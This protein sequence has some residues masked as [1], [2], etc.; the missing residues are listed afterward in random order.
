MTWRAPGLAEAVGG[1]VWFLFI[2]L[3]AIQGRNIAWLTY[4]YVMPVAYLTAVTEVIGIST[5]AYVGVQLFPLSWDSFWRV[6]PMI[7]A[8]GTGG[9]LGCM[10]GMWLHARYAKTDH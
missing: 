2:L 4:R 1:G 7:F 10:A 8:L 6:V 3:K 5:V 9:G